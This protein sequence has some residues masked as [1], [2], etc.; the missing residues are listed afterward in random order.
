MYVISY[1][2]IDND[3][4]CGSRLSKGERWEFV[5]NSND[6]DVLIAIMA[7]IHLASLRNADMTNASITEDVRNV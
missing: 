2:L 4:V 5:W 3:D 1:L 7:V 6:Y